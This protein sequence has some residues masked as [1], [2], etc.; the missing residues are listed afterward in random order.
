MAKYLIGTS[1]FQKPGQRRDLFYPL[2]YE[3]TVK[4]SKPEKIIVLSP[5]NCAIADAPGQWIP[6]SG[7]LGH[8]HDLNQHRKPYHWCD[9]SIGF[10]TL[11]LLAYYNECDFIY[12]EQD[13]LAYGPWVERMYEQIGKNLMI[14]GSA[15]CMPAVQSLVLCKHEFIPMFVHLFFGT[16]SEQVKSNEGELKFNRLSRMH[17]GLFGRYSFGYD[18]DRPFNEKDEVFYVQQCTS[19]DLKQLRA[20]KLLYVTDE[21]IALMQYQLRE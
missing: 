1:F 5:A 6:M 2:W 11:A 4:Y 12:K 13:V 16:G 18:R 17:R 10:C 21:Q 3:N 8:V 20:A 7:D 15:K 14:F 9:W 19:N